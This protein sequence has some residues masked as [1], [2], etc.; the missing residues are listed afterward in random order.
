MFSAWLRF[1]LDRFFGKAGF[2]ESKEGGMNGQSYKG[3]YHFNDDTSP[4]LSVNL[5]E[6]L[7]QCFGV[8]GQEEGSS[9]S[10]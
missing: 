3:L 1:S 8:I 10:L 9:S 6:N 4:S 2:G 7:L 5:H